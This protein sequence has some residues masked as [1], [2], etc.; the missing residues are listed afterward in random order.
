MEWKADSGVSWCRELYEAHAAEWLLYGRAL[1]LGH[2]EAQDVLQDTFVSLLALQQPPA[3]PRH[4]GLRSFRNRALN[5]RRG[6]FRRLARELES[7]RW[8]E[9]SDEIPPQEQAAQR[10]LQTLPREQREVIVLKIWHQLTYEEIGLLLEIS[11]NTAAGR[12]RYG[13]EKL[14]ACL[15]ETNYE[16]GPHVPFG[17]PAEILEPATPFR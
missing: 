8:F 3:N 17:N 16:S 10:C 9:S 2:A 6:L 11:P 12:Y 7:K 13:L 4:Y 5:H 15:G 1:G 14:R